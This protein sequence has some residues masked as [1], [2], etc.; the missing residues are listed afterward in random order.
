MKRGKILLFN[1]LVKGLIVVVLTG[2]V[3][4][5]HAPR[6]AWTPHKPKRVKPDVFPR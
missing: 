6:T 3:S 4:C 2:I 1:L 5:Y